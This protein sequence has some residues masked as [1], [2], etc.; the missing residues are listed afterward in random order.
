MI[1]SWWAAEFTGYKAERGC[2]MFSSQSIQTRWH[3][4]K[5]SI[6]YVWTSW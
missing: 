2:R 4:T 3:T 5:W 6:S 1:R